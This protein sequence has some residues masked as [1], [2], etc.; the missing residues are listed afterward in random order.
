MKALADLVS[1][2]G[3]GRVE[4]YIQSGNVVFEASSTKP[5]TVDLE[6]QLESA[7]ADE[8]GVG[9]AV[10]V[11]TSS[12][13]E[14]II[15]S[16]PFPSFANPRLLHVVFRSARLPSPDQAT[17]DVCVER[18]RSKGNDDQIAVI[19]HTIYLWTPGGYGRS[20]L[21]AQLSRSSES[22]GTARNWATVQRLE[23]ML[24][25]P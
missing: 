11:I 13:L 18:A 8:L 1:S 24:A 17:I 2:L 22:N 16:N 25:D 9:C 3:H 10:V 7:V 20:E 12:E 23:R 6:L 21:A 15:Q 5:Q 19:G 4:T 14:R